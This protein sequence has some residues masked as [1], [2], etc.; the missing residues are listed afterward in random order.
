MLD[1]QLVT[2]PFL[3]LVN[4]EL[5]WIFLLHAYGFACLFFVLG[6]YTFLSVLHLR[7][8]TAL[9]R[10]KREDPSAC[11]KTYHCE[12]S[13]C[14]RSLISSRPFMSTINIFLCLLGASRAACLFIDPYNLKETMPKVIG[15]IIWDIGFPCVTSAFCLVQ[16]AFLQLTQASIYS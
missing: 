16:L 3:S 12:H 4:Q 13:F 1:K 2:A 9:R 7:Y 11:S 15:S 8:S 5:K 14:P 10:G 6:F